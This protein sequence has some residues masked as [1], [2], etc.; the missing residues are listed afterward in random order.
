MIAAGFCSKQVNIHCR[1]ARKSIPKKWR[2]DE[3][4]HDKNQQPELP[5]VRDIASWPSA[6]FAAH[7]VALTL[8]KHQPFGQAWLIGKIHENRR[9]GAGKIL[10]IQESADRNQ[11]KWKWKLWN[12]LRWKEKTN[13]IWMKIFCKSRCEQINCP[14]DTLRGRRAFER[15]VDEVDPPRAHAFQAVPQG[16]DLGS[17]IWNITARLGRVIFQPACLP[18]NSKKHPAH[19]WKRFWY[20]P[21]QLM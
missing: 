2:P 15:P 1:E 18:R 5:A 13:D 8:F 9:G 11:E 3:Q 14:L 6:T 16:A 21:Q 17:V 4:D 10:K 7:L 19:L 12:Y 20:F